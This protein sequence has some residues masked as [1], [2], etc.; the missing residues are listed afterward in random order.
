MAAQDD[1]IGRYRILQKERPKQHNEI[2]ESG[3]EATANL[4]AVETEL[5]EINKKQHSV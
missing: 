2:I 5:A 1:Q 4:L 3:E